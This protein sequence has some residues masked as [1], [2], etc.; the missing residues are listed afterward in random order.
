MAMAMKGGVAMALAMALVLSFGLTAMADGECSV[1]SP[2]RD[3]TYC[4]SQ[5]GYCGTGVPYCGNGCQAGPCTGGTPPSPGGGAVLSDILTRSLYEELFPGHLPFYSYDTLI[6]AA[7]LFPQFGTTGDTNT[8]KREIAAY[9][10][11]V[12]HETSGLFFCSFCKRLKRLFQLQDIHIIL[13]FF[14]LS[15]IA[16][17]W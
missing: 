3:S 11:H 13:G 14:S 17:P 5:F 9:A 12:T 6:E 16:R 2:C 4:C 8:R 1:S 10:A 7:K 15:S